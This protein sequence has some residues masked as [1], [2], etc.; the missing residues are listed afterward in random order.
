MHCRRNALVKNRQHGLA[1]RRRLTADLLAESIELAL[2]HAVAV[3]AAARMADDAQIIEQFRFFDA[4]ART[5]RRCAE[6]LRGHY[7][8]G[9]AS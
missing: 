4:A 1:S 8:A 6:D 5:A 9:S 7:E 2:V 3:L